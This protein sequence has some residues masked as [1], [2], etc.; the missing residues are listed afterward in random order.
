MPVSIVIGGQFG[1]EGKGKTAL[2]IVRRS[3]EP[4]VAIRVG[5]PNSGHTA[6]NHLGSK[7][8]LRQ[9]PAA[10]V[11]RNIDVV[12]PAGSYI[13]VD[14]LLAEIEALDY[15]QNH[16]HISGY[17]RIIRPEHREWEKA[18]GLTRAI[19][20]TGSGVGGAVMATVAREAANF[21]LPS[22]AASDDA[23]LQRFIVD[24]T[25]HYL[26]RHI[27]KGNRVVIEGTQGFGLSLLEGGYWPKATSRSTTAARALAEAGLSPIDVDDITMVIRSFPI[28]VA[29]NSGPLVG[30]T[31][32]EAITEYAGRC[33]DLREYTT[34]TGQLRR[35]GRFNPELVRRALDV[36]R[37]TRLVMNHLD[38][39]GRQQHL[40]DR[41][42]D[43]QK[44][45]L[46]TEDEIGKKSIGSGFP[47]R[48]SLKGLHTRYDRK[49][50]SQC[51]RK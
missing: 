34:V 27:G 43:L 47:D 49:R 17:A 23:R 45:I 42:G 36:N 50:P 24:D 18:A 32:W 1:S 22:Q 28:R 48:A 31:T 25:S 38:Y 13:D 6:Y 29:G 44:F 4:V 39:I 20:S 3:E 19:G 2:E 11:D 40:D 26:R 21:H 10:C 37:P 12:L 9:L 35:V 7:R 5:G 16:I 15:P 8:V 46:Q 14:V 33:D 30:E 41:Q 51:A